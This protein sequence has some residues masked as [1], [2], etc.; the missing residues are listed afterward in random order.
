MLSPAFFSSPRRALGAAL[1][2]AALWLSASGPV[3]A[4][5]AA[6]ILTGKVLTTVTRAV[7][8][9][10]SAVVDDVLVKPGDAVEEGSPLLRYHLQEEAERVL[11]REV[12]T[13]AGT[14]DLMGQVLDFE[15]RLAE[16]T[17]QRNKA[18]QLAASG[19]GSRQAL[20][21]LE[22]D[23]N[24][25]KRRIEL[26]RE[27]I[28]DAE[29]GYLSHPSVVSGP[30][31][32][33]SFDAATGTAEFEINEFYK[34]NSAG[35]TPRIERLVYKNVTNETMISELASGEIDL[36]NKVTAASTLDEGMALAYDD[37]F[38]MSS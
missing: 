27:T 30:Y 26:L 29:T 16:T 24:S 2:C 32:L 11:Q 37:A 12:T 20:T 35:Q 38:Q 10:F 6:T 3:L 4:A 5:E 33:V 14:E 13:G 36:L 23:V 7:P 34:G 18:R 25:L 15:R 19:L 8:I 31:R 28:L 9:P 22:D 21:R 17:A 1:C